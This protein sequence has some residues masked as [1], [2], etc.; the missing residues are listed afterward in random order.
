MWRISHGAEEDEV[1]GPSLDG[2][3]LRNVSMFL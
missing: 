2:L 1:S 3:P